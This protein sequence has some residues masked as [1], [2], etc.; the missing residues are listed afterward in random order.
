MELKEDGLLDT[1]KTEPSEAVTTPEIPKSSE[2]VT[3]LEIRESLQVV[4]DPENLD[5]TDDT[6]AERSMILEDKADHE[7][8]V[9][10]W[11]RK[12][13]KDPK[14]HEQVQDKIVS[15]TYEKLS[16]FNEVTTEMEYTIPTFLW[17]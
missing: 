5:P 9:F 1:E 7:D 3:N 13:V 4:T 11:L 8:K 12:K 16:D 10:D 6:T 14:E 17:G 2:A 15:V